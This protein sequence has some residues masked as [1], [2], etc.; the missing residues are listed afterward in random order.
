MN[1]KDLA[2]LCLHLMVIN[3]NKNNNNNLKQLS[4]GMLVLDFIALI[5]LVIQIYLKD[6]SYSS[7]IVLLICN[8]VVYITYKKNK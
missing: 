7:Y 6:I 3:M 5:N 1:K 8:L 2:V 4:I